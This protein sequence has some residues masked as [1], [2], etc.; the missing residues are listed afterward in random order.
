MSKPTL[1]IFGS[2]LPILIKCIERT[3]GSILDIGMGLSTVIIHMMINKNDRKAYSYESDINWY[4]EYEKY[5]SHKH[6]INF[7]EDWDKVDFESRRW[8]VV[9]VDH[10]PA[11]RR[12]VE[13]KRL[14]QNSDIVLLH[15]CDI[16]A[17]F[18]QQSGVYDLYKYKFIYDLCFPATIALSNTIDVSKLLI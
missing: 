4:K 6:Q 8:S 5:N 15:D 14:A 18:Y 9:L 7:V 10:H 3:N 13:V 12:V 2:H 17:K 16:F 1:D 11:R